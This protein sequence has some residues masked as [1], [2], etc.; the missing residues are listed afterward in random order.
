M[1]RWSL[2]MPKEKRKELKGD[3]YVEREEDEDEI[4]RVTVSKLVLNVQP[5]TPCLVLTVLHSRR[6]PTRTGSL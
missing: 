6:P 1:E 2:Q 4:E 3:K 5:L